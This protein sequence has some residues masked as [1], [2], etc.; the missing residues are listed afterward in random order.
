MQDSYKR[1]QG[2]SKA[3]REL[4]IKNQDLKAA[5]EANRFLMQDA[6]AKIQELKTVLT[7]RNKRIQDLQA[8][9]K[10]EVQAREERHQREVN[11][12]QTELDELKDKT[13]RSMERVLKSV[14]ERENRRVAR[15]ARSLGRSVNADGKGRAM[16]QYN[17]YSR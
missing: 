2:T 14:G 3:K 8:S 11:V 15:Q 9:H 12:L 10:E 16:S 13:L 1:A 4:E 6:D 17:R 5:Q 7:D